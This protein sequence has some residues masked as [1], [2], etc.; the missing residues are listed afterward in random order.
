MRWVAAWMA[1]GWGAMH[2]A[3]GAT[4]AKAL[5]WKETQHIQ[6]T[7]T[8]QCGWRGERCELRQRERQAK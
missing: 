4:D 1:K 7:C 5:G 6:G 8:G 3:L 2:T